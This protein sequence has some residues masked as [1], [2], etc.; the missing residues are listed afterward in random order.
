[1]R[2]VKAPAAIIGD[3]DSVRPEV[4]SF[5]RDECDTEVVR[6]GDQD[7]HDLDK[8]LNYL[9][10]QRHS[11]AVVVVGAFGGRLDHE[12]AALNSLYRW[13]GMFA[14]GLVL[15]SV[16][17]LALLL[18]PGSHRILTHPTLEGPTCGLLPVGGACG[19][20]TTDGLRWDLHD[21]PLG[22][23]GLVSSS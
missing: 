22:F 5:Y 17:S 15:M 18:G 8:C 16:H 2:R 3:L 1:M 19:S 13:Q 11:Q 20:V 4:L 14:G 12:M 7:S 6:D 23:G 9:H 10:T 21:R